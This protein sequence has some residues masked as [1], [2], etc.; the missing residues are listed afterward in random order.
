LWN[1]EISGYG[2]CKLAL[3]EAQSYFPANILMFLLLWLSIAFL[4]RVWNP[5]RNVLQYLITF[6]PYPDELNS[7]A[8]GCPQRPFCYTDKDLQLYFMKSQNNIGSSSGKGDK[9][10]WRLARSIRPH[11]SGFCS[12]SWRLEPCWSSHTG[13]HITWRV[14]SSGIWCRVVRWVTT[15]VSEEYIASILRVERIGSAKP[16]C[17]QVATSV[18]TQR[19]TRRHIPENDTL[20]NHRCENL[21]LYIIILLVLEE[22]MSWIRPRKSTFQCGSDIFT[23]LQP[24]ISEWRYFRRE[25]SL[26]TFPCL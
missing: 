4:W 25:S 18:V 14:S 6:A 22:L 2:W 3:S 21:K 10:I 24:V 9:F 8:Q 12:N 19:T 23:I 15:D 11:F 5:L 7:R 13:N 26:Y 16:A 20:H 17:K 1:T